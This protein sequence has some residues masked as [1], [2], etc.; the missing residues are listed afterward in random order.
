MSYTESNLKLTLNHKLI[1]KPTVNEVKKYIQ[2][3][4]H[5]IKDK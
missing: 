4:Q 3:L 1:L 5:F 2:R